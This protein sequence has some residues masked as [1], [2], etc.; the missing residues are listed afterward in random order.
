MAIEKITIKK[1]GRKDMP[2][3]FKEGEVYSM[4]TILDENGRKMT[5]F[6]DKTESDWTKNWEIGSEV[7]VEVNVKEGKDK[8]GFDVTYYN[9]KNPAK[10]AAGG[11]SKQSNNSNYAIIQAYHIAAAIAPLLLKNEKE[12]NFE[13]I[14]KIANSVKAEIEG[15]KREAE[16]PVVNL[17]TVEKEEVKETK[18][19]EVKFAG[20]EEFDEEEEF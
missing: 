18:T 6:G 9:L 20:E 19:K 2:S 5:A 17:D 15:V 10:K 11:Y 14:V 8:D 3:K 13:S 7:S 1:I 4:V 16:V 12:V